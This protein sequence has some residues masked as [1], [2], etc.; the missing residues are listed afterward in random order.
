M[1]VLYLPSLPL[2][3][4]P[5]FNVNKRQGKAE[6]VRWGSLSVLQV[7]G[8]REHGLS[9]RYSSFFF[10]FSL[11]SFCHSFIDVFTLKI[12]VEK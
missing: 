1:L 5:A 10:Y 12:I 4:S 9:S 2:P 7:K 11:F 6:N 8:E 3:A